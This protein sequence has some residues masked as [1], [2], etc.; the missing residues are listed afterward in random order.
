MNKNLLEMNKN[1]M[2]SRHFSMR[3]TKKMTYPSYPADILNNESADTVQDDGFQ[4]HDFNKPSSRPLTKKW[5]KDNVSY[6]DGPL[7][8][9]QPLH[10]LY[11]KANES[12][13]P[14]MT[15]LGYDKNI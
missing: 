13:I 2:F 14:A 4:P 15:R 10:P 3:T 8:G 11:Y 9:L 12:K 6:G 7:Q 5:R 1:V